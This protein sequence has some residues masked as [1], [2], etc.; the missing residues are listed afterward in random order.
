MSS[1]RATW[2]PAPRTPTSRSCWW[3]PARVLLTQTCRHAE[4]ASLLGIR[5][6]VLAIN[7]IDLVD[8][9]QAVFDE[10]AGAFAEGGP[11]ACAECSRS[12]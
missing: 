4:I 2:S 11:R 8:Y 12:R 9:S 10:I 5:H 7:K 3:T 6:V 1:T